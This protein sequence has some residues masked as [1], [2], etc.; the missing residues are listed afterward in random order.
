MFGI[1]RGAGGGNG[2][3]LS[4][5]GCGAFGGGSSCVER[6][7]IVSASFCAD[8]CALVRVPSDCWTSSTFALGFLV[9]RGAAGGT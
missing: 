7:T 5:V 8:H 1:D 4:C 3:S 6:T 9:R 2:G